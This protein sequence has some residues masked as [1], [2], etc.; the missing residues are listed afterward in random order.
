MASTPKP[1][2]VAIA[3]DCPHCLANLTVHMVARIELRQTKDQQDQKIKCAK[4]SEYFDVI[5]PERII[6]GPFL[7]GDSKWP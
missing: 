5:V 1:A 7:R 2:Y 3:V 4:C 6:D